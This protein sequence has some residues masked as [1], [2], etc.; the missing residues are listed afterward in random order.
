MILEISADFFSQ[1]SVV[2]CVPPKPLLGQKKNQNHDRAKDRNP[3]V[4]DVLMHV[5]LSIYK[6]TILVITSVNVSQFEIRKARIPER[7][8]ISIASGRM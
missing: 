1:A 4:K 6:V 3:P 7:F 5:M 8:A 2:L